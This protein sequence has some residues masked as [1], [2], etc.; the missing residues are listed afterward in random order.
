MPCVCS[1]QFDLK[2]SIAVVLKG[3]PQKSFSTGILVFQGYGSRIGIDMART[4]N[5]YT[6]T[7]MSK[8]FSSHVD[9]VNFLFL[10]S[11]RKQKERK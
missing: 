4:V 1:G 7:C 10:Q 3:V 2:S 9:I 5:T 11:G 8:L 6:G